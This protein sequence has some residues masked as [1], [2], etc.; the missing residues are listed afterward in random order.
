MSVSPVSVAD[1]LRP[2]VAEVEADAA[3]GD[4]KAQRVIDLYEMHRTCP[5]DPGARGLCL[6]A[7]ADWKRDRR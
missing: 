7:F 6:A 3:A 1:T 5:N 4:A 2:H